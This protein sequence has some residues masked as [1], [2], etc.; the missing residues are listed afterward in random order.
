MSFCLMTVLNLGRIEWKLNE[1]VALACFVWVRRLIS[2]IWS[3]YH[4]IHMML[5][6]WYDDDIMIIWWYD[7]YMMIITIWWSDRVLVETKTQ[8]N[9]WMRAVLRIKLGKCSLILF[10]LIA[11][12]ILTQNRQ[13]LQFLPIGHSRGHGREPEIENFTIPWPSEMSKIISIITTITIIID[14]VADDHPLAVVG[15]LLVVGG[16]AVPAARAGAD[17]ATSARIWKKSRRCK[18]FRGRKY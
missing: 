17:G 14:L 8:M 16:G 9:I 15:D 4:M 13:L 10:H 2:K 18:T 6:W 3:S 7:V 5:W 1:L 11:K 12:L